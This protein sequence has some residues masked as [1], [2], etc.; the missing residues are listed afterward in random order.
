[1]FRFH[2]FLWWLLPFQGGPGVSRTRKAW[3]TRSPS[4][5]K[6]IWDWVE[7][8]IQPGFASVE[9]WW[10]SCT[11]ASLC[12]RRDAVVPRTPP[13]FWWRIW[14]MFAAEPWAGGALAGL[15]PMVNRTAMVSLEP[16]ASLASASTHGT[17]PVEWS[18]LLNALLMA[19]NRLC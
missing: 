19:A 17:R 18:H 13:T 16:T 10:C 4:C 6:L 9:L 12:W 7:P 15:W 5:R 2:L 3:L 1:M 8:L 14:W 11:P